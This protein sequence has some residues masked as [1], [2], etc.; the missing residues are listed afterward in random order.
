MEDTKELA[1]PKPEETALAKTEHKAVTRA[2]DAQGRFISKKDRL[3]SEK[4]TIKRREFLEGRDP[5]NPKKTRVEVVDEKLYELVQLGTTDP[6][7]STAAVNAAKQLA[8]RA[9]GRTP[10]SDKELDRLTTFPVKMV[11]V[12]PM[13]GIRPMEERPPGPRKPNFAEE[14]PSSRNTIE[15]EYQ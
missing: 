7:Y 11:I 15:G 8:E 1:Q 10:P 3:G 6:K 5:N 4:Y 9:H 2:K 13:E 14:V 12:P